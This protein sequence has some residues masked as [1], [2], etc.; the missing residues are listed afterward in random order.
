MHRRLHEST[1]RWLC[2]GA[3]LGLAMLPMAGISLYCVW[4]QLPWHRARTCAHWQAVL[5]SAC[6]L[7][8]QIDRA[9]TPAPRVV[10]LH[11]VSLLHPET[12]E[13]LG[14]ASRIRVEHVG[15]QWLLDVDQVRLKGHRLDVAWQAIEP[16]ILQRPGR[17]SVVSLAARDV[18]V[19]GLRRS[20]RLSDLRLALL[21]DASAT[22]LSVQFR[23][24]G[25]EVVSPSREAVSSRGGSDRP[26]PAESDGGSDSAMARINIMRVH[27]DADLPTLFQL[28][29]G[30][31]PLPC[32]LLAPFW[33]S[34]VPLGEKASL[35]GIV[36]CRRS[37]AEWRLMIDDRG[38]AIQGKPLHEAGG[39]LLQD[40]DFAALPWK[41]GMGL[42]GQGWI[43]IGQGVVSGQ[44]IELLRGGMRCGPGRL[45]QRLLDML[46]SE[47]SVEIDS[48]LQSAAVAMVPYEQGVLHFQ[49]APASVRIAGAMAGGA[50]L[51]DRQG[52]LASRGDWQSDI[53]LQNLAAVLGQVLDVGENAPGRNPFG[54]LASGTALGG[55][56]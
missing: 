21:P 54:R 25:P 20:N 36:D 13:L 44:G 8:V 50:M 34:L 29:T 19:E 10:L 39:L 9:D 47:L 26:A 32:T 27:Q 28:R 11:G 24:P 2:Q 5:T 35:L 52:V 23:G 43:W 15:G 42:T 45:S 46:A 30:A 1:S 3:L 38:G 41:P 4:A 48:G 18:Q 6:G 56:R 40:V 31:T 7:N 14:S 55:G 37:R 16:F 17:V 12:S 49:I 53:P 33:P 51:V 22:R